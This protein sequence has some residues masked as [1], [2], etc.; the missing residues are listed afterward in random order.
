MRT[1]TATELKQNSG[2]VLDTALQIPVSI[3]KHGRA[4]AVLSSEVEY[5]EFL[6]YR[7]VKREVEAGFAQIGGGES[8]YR[9]MD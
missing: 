6:K 2:K 5:Q 4:V 1:F 3:L 7:Q 8:S 9:S